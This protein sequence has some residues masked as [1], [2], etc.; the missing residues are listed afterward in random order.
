MP[1]RT[2]WRSTARLTSFL[3]I[4]RCTGHALLWNPPKYLR[5]DVRVTEAA[6]KLMLRIVIVLA[7]GSRLAGCSTETPLPATQA[8]AESPVSSV[9]PKFTAEP[10]A[11]PT[12]ID[13][14]SR[15]DFSVLLSADT[16]F[17][18]DRFT[19]AAAGRKQLD[20][21]IVDRLKTCK[22]VDVVNVTGHTDR[23]G[24]AAMNQQL[25]ER[26]AEA[27]EGLFGGSRRFCRADQCHRPRIEIANVITLRRTTGHVWR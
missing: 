10:P 11:A 8:V 6:L 3:G 16:L 27:V 5:H 19:I 15:C 26:R 21:E 22:S 9:P 24:V 12:N 13:R 25:S 18:H 4:L 7:L 23:L 20:D 1:S 2:F 14:Q 17:T